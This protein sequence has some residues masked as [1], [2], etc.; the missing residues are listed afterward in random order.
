MSKMFLEYI[1]V[2][3]SEPT[4][5]LRS[6]TKVVSSVLGSARYGL[7]NWGFDG[8]STNQATGNKSDCILQPVR[9]FADP[10]RANSYLVMCEVMNADG[11]P[12]PSNQRAKLRAILS[13]G[14]DNVDSWFGFE[15]EYVFMKGGKPLG[16]PAEGEPGP[17]G[18]YYCGVGSDKVAGR[19]IVDKHMRLC[20]DAGLMIEGTNF[21]VLLGQAEF[22]IGAGNPL[23]I[24]D[25]LW[26]ARWL[27]QRLGE[28]YGVCVS[29][30]PKPLLGAWNG[31][32]C[33]ANVSLARTRIPSGTN[34]DS[35]ILG[36]LE[37]IFEICEKF[38]LRSP[39]HI[40][41]YGADNSLRLTGKHE[42]CDINTFRFGVADRGA[43]IRI[44]QHVANQGFGYF[45]D[46]RPAANADP[47]QVCSVILK[48][49]CDLW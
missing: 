14:A 23:L 40:A 13:A 42:T 47:Y 2:D 16:W 5:T 20:A 6:K 22:Q 30:H 11:T 36:G 10:T 39:E 49:I 31:S 25:Q 26:L 7:P 1:W 18:P 9:I 38:R 3:G 35:T 37:L 19:E 8:S 21:E 12:H 43:S 15:Q 28:D 41:A 32:G 33:H 45:E 29:W 44:P 46:R 17:Q 27:L 24:A 34:S 48:T 4:Q